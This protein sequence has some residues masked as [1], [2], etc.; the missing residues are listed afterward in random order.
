MRNLDVIK[1]IYR[2]NGVNRNWTI[3][4]EY[5]DTSQICVT[6]TTYADG[7]YTY[8]VID[9]ADY[10]IN[11]GAQTVTYPKTG[12]DPISSSQYVTV[13]RATDLLQ[14][15]DLTNQGG[16]WPETI[17]ASVD[18]LHQIVQELSEGLS[19]T[20]KVDIGD[21]ETPEQKLLDLQTYVAETAASAAAAAESADD[22]AGSANA[23]A[24]SA[25]AAADSAAESE[26]QA[27]AAAEYSASAHYSAESADAAAMRAA[28]SQAASLANLVSRAESAVAAINAYAVPPWDANTVYS[29]PAVVS[30]TDGQTYRC[31]GENVPAGT[32]P[33]S[34]Q[35]WMRITTRGGD[36]FWEI[37][38]WGCYMPAENPTASYS[39]E[40][41]ENGCIMPRI[42]NDNTGRE[43]KTVAEE[44]LEEATAATAAAQEATAAANA[45]IAATP[46]EIDDDGNVT[47]VAIPEPEE[48]EE[49]E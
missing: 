1:G 42:A 5:N 44:A 35:L 21:P 29:Y 25:A 7:D 49:D 28:A 31:I 40:L 39:W 30:Y 20:L 18:K 46:M 10:T 8:E 24:A 6:L 23:A 11:T 19:R 12:I 38:A 43:A 15:M 22:A 45:L 41:D 9:S 47:P 4:F 32:A 16:A 27:H 33:P 17:E 37:D 34:S 3:P 14:L 26:N 48:E 13:W 36:D 2:G